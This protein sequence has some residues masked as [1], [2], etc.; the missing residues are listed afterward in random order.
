MLPDDFPPPSTVYYHVR[1]SGL[2]HRTLVILWAAERKRVG[3]DPSASASIVDSQSVRPPWREDRTV[4]TTTRTLRVAS[5]PCWSAPWVCR[6]R[7]LS[8]PADVQDRAGALLI[9]EPKSL[10]PRL[11]KLREDPEAFAASV[12]EAAD[13]GS[14]GSS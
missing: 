9:A 5:A 4:A 3:E 7:S 2:W 11:K 12:Y 8:T 10:V 14:A 1:M 13:H 6:S